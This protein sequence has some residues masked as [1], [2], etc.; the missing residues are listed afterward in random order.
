MEEVMAGEDV[1][2]ARGGHPVV[3]LL[4]FEAAATVRKPGSMKGRI[5]MSRNFDAPLPA[6]MFDNSRI[7]P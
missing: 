3:R 7:E 1:V 5:R 6:D 2:I 4:R